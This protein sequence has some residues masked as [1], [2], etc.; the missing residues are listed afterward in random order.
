MLR[1]TVSK[2]FL[3]ST[4]APQ[5]KLPLSQ[6]SQILFAT[7]MKAWLV[8]IL[9][10]K[11]Y[12]FS[13]RREFFFKKIF[14]SY[15]LIFQLAYLGLTLEK[16]DYSWLSPCYCYQVNKIWKWLCNY[17]SIICCYFIQKM[18]IKQ[19]DVLT[20]LR[21]YTFIIKLVLRKF[22]KFLWKVS[23]FEFGVIEWYDRIRI[24]AEWSDI[25]FIYNISWICIFSDNITHYIVN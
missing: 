9:V 8:D 15:E 22:L 17:L 5:A 1:L 13:N 12:C 18:F 6:V 16:L 4:K 10:R 11:Y 3:K 2:A 14:V 7:S 25:V 21:K 20:I 19:V 23:C 24:W